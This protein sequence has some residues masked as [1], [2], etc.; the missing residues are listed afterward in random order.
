MCV[1]LCL[2]ILSKLVFGGWWSFILRIPVC[3]FVAFIH[4][5]SQCSSI[6]LQCGYQLLTVTLN[7]FSCWC[8]RWPG[9]AL[10]RISCHCVINNK[11]LDCVCGARLIQTRIIVCSLCFHLLLQEFDTSIR[12][13]SV[14]WENVP[15]YE[16]LLSSPG[17]YVGWPSLYCVWHRSVGW[18]SRSSQPSVA[19]LSCVFSVCRGA[20]SCNVWLRYSHLGQFCFF[21]NNNNSELLKPK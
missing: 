12:V 19:H 5:F 9:F 21:N 11:L 17:S 3:C 13:R 15:I 7:F 4:L 20:D 2:L 1:V 8:V 6:V 18:V 14:N 16:V 10:M